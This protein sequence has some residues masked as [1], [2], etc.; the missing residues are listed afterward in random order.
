MILRDLA[1][2]VRNCLGD[3]PTRRLNALETRLGHKR[4]TSGPMFVARLTFI[5][6]YYTLLST[7]DALNHICLRVTLPHPSAFL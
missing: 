5:T 3:Q 4:C 6:R 1:P 7:D 2:S